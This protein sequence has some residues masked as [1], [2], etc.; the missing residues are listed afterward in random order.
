MP[1]NAT[2]EVAT[3]VTAYREVAGQ[4]AE[5]PVP[6]TEASAVGQT[7]LD[8]SWGCGFPFF[9]GY[10]FPLFSMAMSGNEDTR[11]KTFTDTRTALLA[12][13]VGVGALAT[14]WP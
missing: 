3:K 9:S 1:Y 5:R 6:T 10:D 2:R 8:L 12:G 11:I 7:H 14:F 13:L 4:V